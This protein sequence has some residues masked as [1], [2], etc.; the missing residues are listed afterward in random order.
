[1]GSLLGSLNAGEALLS[2][3]ATFQTMVGVVGASN[4][5]PFIH[6]GVED[7]AVLARESDKDLTTGYGVVS[8]PEDGGGLSLESIAGGGPNTYE[9]R[10]SVELQLV[11]PILTVDQGDAN[12][13]AAW[14][15]F[16]TVLDGIIED[17]QALS[18]TG[19]LMNVL[20]IEVLQA[21]VM[22]PKDEK[23]GKGE[24]FWASL[25]LDWGP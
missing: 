24:Y 1:M 7:A 15:A 16:T 23:T 9:G 22:N 2:N 13:A 17:I 3:S 12:V 10:G 4:A 14:L 5:L 21:P 20:G 8:L 11:D 25:R 18:G 6:V 19:V